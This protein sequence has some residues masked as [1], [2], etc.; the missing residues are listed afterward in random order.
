VEAYRQH[1]VRHGGKKPKQHKVGRKTMTTFE[2]AEMLGINVITL[3]LYM[4]RHKASLA[5]AIRFYEKKKLKQA[6]KDI[7]AILTE[8]ES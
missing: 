5:Q 4:S 8:G 6:E 2:A 1:Q 3:R 7:L